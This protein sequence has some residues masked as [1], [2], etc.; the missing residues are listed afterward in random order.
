MRRFKLHTGISPSYEISRDIYESLTAKNNDYSWRGADGKKRPLA[1]CPACDNPIQ[2][3]G[4]YK[5]LQNTE[6]PYGKHFQKNTIIAKYNAQAYQFCPYASHS[7][8][9]DWDARK[10]EMTEYEERILKTVHDY[11]DLAVYIIEQETGLYVSE[12]LARQMVKGYI[13]SEGYMYYW[14]TVYNIPW[15]LLYFMPSRPCYGLVVKQDSPLWEYLSS[16]NDV[17]LENSFKEGYDIVKNNGKFLNLNLV[18]LLHDRKLIQDEVVET[19]QMTVNTTGKDRLPKTQY[20]K[21]LH[22]NEYRFPEF[23]QHAKYR[24][25]KLLAIADELMGD[26]YGKA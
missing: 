18:F 10:K 4:L 13:E 1:I 12:N 26:I 6:H 15:M 24:N 19:L 21:E 3:I 5:K 16:R 25:R 2:L 14:A 9:V 11:F 20:K 8:H 7:Y 17:L 22:I 23:V